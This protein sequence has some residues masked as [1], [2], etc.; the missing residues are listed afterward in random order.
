MRIIGDYDIDGICSIYI[1]LTGLKRVGANVDYEIPHRVEDGYGINTRLVD[2]AFEDG[3][4]TII[5]CD[6]GIAAIEQINYAKK[7]GMAVIVT[8]HHD[9]PYKEENGKK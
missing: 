3:V 7:L 5:T 2:K 8:D 1:L 6:N 9:I 4:D